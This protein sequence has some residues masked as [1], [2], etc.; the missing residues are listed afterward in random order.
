MWRGKRGHEAREYMQNLLGG[1]V[2]RKKH[3]VYVQPRE[4]SDWRLDALA[5]F[6]SE[7]IIESDKWDKP[8][9]VQADKVT[10]RIRRDKKWQDEQER[11]RKINLKLI[12]MRI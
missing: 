4:S 12:L 9:H 10:L 5:V 3:R 8:E 7:L 6:V 1:E 2:R 11:K